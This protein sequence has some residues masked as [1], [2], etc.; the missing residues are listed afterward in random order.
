MKFTPKNDLLIGRVVDIIQSKG[1][2]ELAAS[3]GKNVTL[4]MLVD[5]VGPAVKSCAP[6]DIIIYE[7]MGHALF[8]DGTH[9]G[10]VRDEKVVAVVTELDPDSIHIE[11]DKRLAAPKQPQSTAAQV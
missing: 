8:R 11:G 2:L 1:G 3:D 9:L 7:A 5:A 4:L 6:G 10:I